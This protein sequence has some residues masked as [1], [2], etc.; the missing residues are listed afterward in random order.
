MGGPMHT[1][2]PDEAASLRDI[3]LTEDKPNAVEINHQT[4]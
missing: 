3:F 1:T 4:N 2:A